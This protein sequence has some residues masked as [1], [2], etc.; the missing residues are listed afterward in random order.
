MRNTEP[1]D[2]MNKVFATAGKRCCRWTRD[3]RM[4]CSDS[5]SDSDSG[6]DSDSSSPPPTHPLSHRQRAPD[7]VSKGPAVK[8][9]MNHYQIFITQERVR[10]L[11]A[12]PCDSRAPVKKRPGAG[13]GFYLEV[14]QASLG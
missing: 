7:K 12:S 5:D 2:Y 8:R 4:R 1:I 3:V 10:R 13:Y 14:P 6:S 9:P 11:P